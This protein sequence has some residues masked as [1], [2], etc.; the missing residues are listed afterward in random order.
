MARLLV[1]CCLLSLG[2]R[3]VLAVRDACAAV[4]A[5]VQAHR[6]DHCA[7]AAKTGSTDNRVD[8]ASAAKA[9]IVVTRG[10]GEDVRWLDALPEFPAVVYNRKGLPALLPKARSNLRVEQQNNTGREDDAMLRHIINNYEHLPEVTFFLQG[11]PF[12]HCADTLGT[13]RKSMKS[14][15]TPEAK[16]LGNGAAQGL[17][18]LAATFY[19]YSTADGFIGNFWHLA[20]AN[21]KARNQTKQQATEFAKTAWSS[22]CQS[23]LGSNCSATLWV[24]EGS[25]WAVS[26][27]RIQRH[28]K[29]FYQKLL[30]GIPASGKLRGLVLEAVWPQLW[31]AADWTPGEA[32]QYAGPGKLSA[33]SKRAESLNDHCIFSTEKGGAATSAD[34]QGLCELET[35][36]SHPVGEALR[37]QQVPAGSWSMIAELRPIMSYTSSKGAVLMQVSSEK[38]RPIPPSPPFCSKRHIWTPAMI[39]RI[40]NQ[41]SGMCITKLSEGFTVA[42][43]NDNL[44][45]QQWQFVSGANMGLYQIQDRT[46][47]ACIAHDW[48]ASKVHKCGIGLDG[49]AVPNQRWE[50]VSRDGG[51]YQVKIK[52]TQKCMA[53]GDTGYSIGDCKSNKTKEVTWQLVDAP[54]MG[55]Y[56]EKFDFSMVAK[57]DGM[58]KLR[59]AESL[60]SADPHASYDLVQPEWRNRGR[61]V[62]WNVTDAAAVGAPGSY[63]LERHPRSAGAPQYLSCDNSTGDARLSQAQVPWKIAPLGD[64]FVTLESAAGVLQFVLEGGHLRCKPR[65]G[66][67]LPAGKVAFGLSLSAAAQRVL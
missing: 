23:V 20:Q 39:T 60:H 8:A 66:G 25:Q 3:G 33:A 6:F 22:T 36:S 14:V 19:Q 2:P 54:G 9:Q 57:G 31:G 46:S 32:V 43:C 15:L 44:E 37:L 63:L 28:P 47:A 59:C 49:S 24:S 61:R 52:D 21:R 38:P 5:S 11:W 55:Q 27:E 48:L 56:F 53:H 17:V 51:L 50:L 67:N 58:V 29:A 13:V 34:L 65:A 18:P 64:G 1:A 42:H 7:A 12:W 41:A 40:K 35:H 30:D 16:L 62:Q 45:S 4:Q 26:R 10:T